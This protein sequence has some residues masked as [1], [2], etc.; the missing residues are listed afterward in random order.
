MKLFITVWPLYV[1]QVFLTVVVVSMLV[2]FKPYLLYKVTG[3]IQ[4]SS[5]STTI[6][7]DI[8]STNGEQYLN[9]FGEHS[10]GIHYAFGFALSIMTLGVGE[11][12]L[13]YWSKRI[14]IRIHSIL[15]N[16]I[17]GKTMRRASGTSGS[18]VG[19]VGNDGKEDG[20]KA[21]DNTSGKII[22]LMSSDTEK[23]REFHAS[24]YFKD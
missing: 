22:S 16:E 15:V 1:I 5:N 11:A 7:P 19:D 24:E 23:L 18:I 10:E 2:I 4:N 17:F 13:W 6:Y 20:T 12:H 8:L 21:K 9:F 3:Y 14:D